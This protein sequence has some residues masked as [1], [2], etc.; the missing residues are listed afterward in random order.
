MS[1]Y[2]WKTAPTI[3]GPVV[4]CRLKKGRVLFIAGTPHI[5]GPLFIFRLNG[6]GVVFYYRHTA[7]VPCVGRMS[8]GGFF[9]AAWASPGH[10][11][12]QGDAG[13]CCVP[14]FCRWRSAGECPPWRHKGGDGPV[15]PQVAGEVRL[16]SPGVV[17]LCIYPQCR[18]STNSTLSLK[19]KA[20][21]ERITSRTE[22]IPRK[23]LYPTGITGILALGSQ[24]Q[25]RNSTN[26]T[27]SFEM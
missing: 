22:N 20:E 12:T 13:A 6:G 16:A 4:L 10:K 5:W 17:C 24:S 21:K 2:E 15:F 8:P 14:V 23:I 1:E 9:G 25:C 7:A 27:L 3:W 18:S 19:Y 11:A 26:S